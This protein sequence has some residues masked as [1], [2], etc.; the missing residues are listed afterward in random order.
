[1]LPSVTLTVKAFVSCSGGTPLGMYKKLIEFHKAGRLSFKYV[2]TFNMDEYVG[3]FLV[4]SYS[5]QLGCSCEVGLIIE[6]VR[7]FCGCLECLYLLF[8]E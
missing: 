5:V 8:L 2:K 6:L 1:M 4:R 3:K 7:L